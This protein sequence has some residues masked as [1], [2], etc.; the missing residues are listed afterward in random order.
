M[1]LSFQTW[2]ILARWCLL[3][4]NVITY[5]CM[6]YFQVNLLKNIYSNLQ[7]LLLNINM[8]R[9]HGILDNTDLLTMLKAKLTSQLCAIHS[10]L[11]TEQRLFDKKL[12]IPSCSLS[13]PEWR[14]NRGSH[15]KPSCSECTKYAVHV[16]YFAIID[17]KQYL[18]DLDQFF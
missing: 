11:K 10:M 16:V 17:M 6:F 1:L 8:L 2:K 18:A 13:K 7:E 3:K 12:A 4:S 15:K 9:H 14:R 5:T